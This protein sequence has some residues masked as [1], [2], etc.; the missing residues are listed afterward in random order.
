M[1]KKPTSRKK[2]YSQPR[3][4]RYGDLRTLTQGGRRNMTELAMGAPKTRTMTG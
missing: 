1:K 3:L 4:V 2:A